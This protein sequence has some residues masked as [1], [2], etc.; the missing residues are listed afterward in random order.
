MSH[1]HTRLFWPARSSLHFRASLSSL[2][3]VDDLRLW[4]LKVAHI[5]F[6]GLFT[7]F[8]RAEMFFPKESVESRICC[9]C[10]DTS[11]K[12]KD[13]EVRECDDFWGTNLWEMFSKMYLMSRVYQN[14]Q[15]KSLNLTHKEPWN[16]F[17]NSVMLN[18]VV[19]LSS[20]S[21]AHQ[22]AASV[23]TC[24][25]KK[26]HVFTQLKQHH[27]FLKRHMKKIFK[28]KE[29]RDVGFTVTG[30]T[31]EAIP[32]WIHVKVIRNVSPW[33]L[34]VFVWRY[35]HWF[36]YYSNNPGFQQEFSIQ[37]FVGA[38]LLLIESL[39]TFVKGTIQYLNTLTCSRRI[40]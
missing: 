27:H 6:S 20:L 15:K 17:L 2:V 32:M 16:Y 33:W 18:S 30:N 34:V 31:R 25:Q 14:E 24:R 29:P 10:R 11:S 36:G 28:V 12:V 39:G 13:S 38:Q 7:S 22:P 5:F 19:S 1:L 3:C 26:I 23:F 37:T 4:W 8:H 21:L 40:T 35:I 9:G